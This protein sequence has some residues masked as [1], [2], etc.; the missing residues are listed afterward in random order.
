[1]YIYTMGERAYPVEMA[2]LLDPEKIYIESKVITRSDC[3]LELNEGL[4]VSAD[5]E[6][7][8]M[9]QKS[10]MPAAA[11]VAGQ[12]DMSYDLEVVYAV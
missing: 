6:D 7:M 11:R 1:M 5:Q 3:T 10:S 8:C 9:T 12:D 2:N 4:D